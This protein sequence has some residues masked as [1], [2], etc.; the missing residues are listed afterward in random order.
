M[1]VH[2]IYDKNLTKLTKN[3]KICT[4]IFDTNN[5]DKN[6]CRISEKT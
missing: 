3:I 4:N 1:T 6:R 2:N 5:Y